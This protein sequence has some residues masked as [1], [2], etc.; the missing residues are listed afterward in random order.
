MSRPPLLTRRGMRPNRHVVNSFT[1]SKPWVFGSA[2]NPALKGR[3]I[4][5]RPG[6]KSGAASR[7][8]LIS[9]TNEISRDEIGRSELPADKDWKYNP[10][11]GNRMSKSFMSFV[12]ALSVA[13]LFGLPFHAQAQAPAARS[14]TIAERTS[15]MQKLD[16]FFP[17]YW[18]E[19]VGILWLEIPRFDTEVL[20]TTGR[21]Q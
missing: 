11:R 20:Y 5:C 13:V 16:G 12:L 6:L 14:Q 19:G 1:R 21:A 7:P 17:L 2:G 9:L 10:D 3:Q 4:F 15:G 8:I 18:D